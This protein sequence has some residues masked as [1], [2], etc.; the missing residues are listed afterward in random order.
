MKKKLFKTLLLALCVGASTVVSAQ[1][2][3]PSTNWEGTKG[4]AA[5][6]AAATKASKG[7]LMYGVTL[8]DAT[9]PRNYV[10][11]YSHTHEFLN[12]LWK[13]DENWEKNFNILGVRSGAWCG[14]GYYGYR[15]NMYTGWPEDPEAFIK[16]DFGGKKVDVVRDFPG[17]GAEN[18][19]WEWIYDMT[20][21]PTHD[22]IYGIG[23]FM[24]DDGFAFSALYS[25]NKANGEMTKL[26]ELGFY[27]WAIGCDYDGTLY[28]IRGILNKKEEYVAVELVKLDKD[29]NVVESEN[30]RITRDGDD[31]EP[32]YYHSLDFD[33]QTGDLYYLASNKL[34]Y[35]NLIKIDVKTGKCETTRSMGNDMVLGLYIPFEGGATLQAAGKVQ[36]LQA[37]AG[38]KGKLETT[39]SWKNPTESWRAGALTELKS[40]QIARETRSNVIGTVTATG[41]GK[42][43]TWTDASPKKGYN[44]YYL[45]T[46]RI[47]GEKG[48]TDS[49]EVFV[50]DDAPGQPTNVK[51]QI[52]N[53]EATLT[54]TPSEVGKNGGWYD[55]TKTT[56]RIVRRPG[57][58]PVAGSHT[59]TTF[60]E[61]LSERQRYSYEITAI[62]AEG[63]SEKAVSEEVVYGAALTI[64]YTNALATFDDFNQWTPVDA[65]HDGQAWEWFDVESWPIY[66]GSYCPNKPHD[67]LV[68][69][70]LIFEKGKSYKVKYQYMSAPYKDTEERL[71]IA[72]GTKPDG[73]DFKIVQQLEGVHTIQAILDEQCTFT[74]DFEGEGYVA[75]YVNSKPEQGWIRVRNFSIREY[76][77]KDVAA[78]KLYGNTLVNKETEDRMIV[79][80]LN[81][82]NAAVNDYKVRLIDV[83]TKAVLGEGKGLAVESEKTVEVPINWTPAK[84]GEFKVHA[85]V[86]LMGDTY[87]DDDTTKKPVAVTVQEKDKDRWITLNQRNQ[88]GWIIPFWLM[89]HYG[90]NQVLYLPEELQN[91]KDITIVGIQFAYDGKSGGE[92]LLDIPVAIS[93]KNTTQRELDTKDFDLDGWTNVYDGE[94]SVDGVGNDK[95]VGIMFDQGFE[96]TGNSLK[97]KLEKLPTKTLASDKNHPQW[98]YVSTEGKPYRTLI[99]INKAGTEVDLEKI[100]RMEY[101]PIARI[102]YKKG[103]SDI[104][105]TFTTQTTPA[106]VIGKKVYL[107]SEAEKVELVATTG[108]VV[109]SG[110]NVSML[111]VSDV[112]EGIYI[113]RILNDGKEA[114]LK[115]VVK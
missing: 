44:K 93:M 113:L 98:H 33:H 101:M 36:D 85:Q 22:K 32:N 65:N 42:A 54:W 112:A 9:N 115:I 86:D 10:S 6:P 58:V 20:Y 83:E 108:A 39:L 90:Q 52:V 61:K 102:A 80:V 46:Y 109:A 31:I 11:F 78:V 38:E 51:L 95:H 18:E 88:D 66:E 4:F 92:D 25:I 35:Q 74:A 13:V 45:T 26:S 41:I 53:G 2:K 97:V 72:V 62:N 75:F 71:A 56:Y 8:R 34:G 7:L 12:R 43:Q 63:E 104:I 24:T 17:H 57:N 114:V 77:G 14:D 100:A 82:G 105:K 21:D 81:N 96:Y 37:T 76:S 103:T 3:F 19:E 28:A 73:S 40:V 68:S 1:R 47:D 91:E 29:Y 49:I 106:E 99:Y 23:R 27:A 67:Y 50:G 59:S 94:I 111:D 55:K 15:V 69:P 89:Y 30:K 110:R 70:P 5:P 60:T 16:V 48:L 79:T 64:P 107:K 84:V 87:P